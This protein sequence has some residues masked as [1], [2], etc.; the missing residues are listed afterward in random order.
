MASAEDRFVKQSFRIGLDRHDEDTESAQLRMMQIVDPLRK[1]RDTRTTEDQREG[2][3]A[4]T[5]IRRAEGSHG[6]EC[7]RDF[8]AVIAGNPKN[9]SS[10]RL[11]R[12]DGQRLQHKGI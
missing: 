1:G 2:G 4:P 5:D 9:G 6:Q 10:Q 12:F 11:K 3:L 7:Q 8:A